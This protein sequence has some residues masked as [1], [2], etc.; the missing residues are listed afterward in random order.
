MIFTFALS[1]CTKLGLFVIICL[2]C[3]PN[4]YCT[5]TSF[6]SGTFET[7]GIYVQDFQ[8]NSSQQGDAV[9]EIIEQIHLKPNI[10]PSL[11]IKNERSRREIHPYIFRSMKYECYLYVHVNFGNDLLSTI[12]SFE[13]PLQSALYKAGTFLILVKSRPYEMVTRESQSSHCD[14]Q[15]RIFVI[16]IEKTLT[17]R[18][19]QILSKS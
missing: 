11:I 1:L 12:P 7:C 8:L 10:R 2:T 16:K 15:Y 5:C 18:N 17:T 14:L 6:L 4:T 19:N 9:H 3:N 13:N